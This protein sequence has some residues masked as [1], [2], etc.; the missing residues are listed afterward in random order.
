MNSYIVCSLSGSLSSL[1]VGPDDWVGTPHARSQ[2]L[3]QLR[4]KGLPEEGACASRRLDKGLGPQGWPELLNPRSLVSLGGEARKDE[5]LSEGS[6]EDVAER[7]GLS[8]PAWAGVSSAEDTWPSGAGGRPSAVWAGPL[9]P[10]PC[11]SMWQ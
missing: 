9:H 1:P 4:T 2:P 3:T 6:G 8:P 5:R 11:H 7:R 10:P